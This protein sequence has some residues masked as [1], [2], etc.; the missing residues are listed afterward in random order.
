MLSNNHEVNNLFEKQIS[1]K[2][3]EELIS[4]FDHVV[5]SS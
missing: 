3:S 5:L 4:K 2:F 1:Y